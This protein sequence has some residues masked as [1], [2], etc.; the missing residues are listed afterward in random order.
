MKVSNRYLLCRK[1]AHVL[2]LSVR[3][4]ATLNKASLSFIFIFKNDTIFIVEI[5]KKST[6]PVEIS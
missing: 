1:I 4:L 3:K 5:A 2:M 6:V